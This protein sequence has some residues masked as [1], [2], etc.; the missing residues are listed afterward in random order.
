MNLELMP[1]FQLLEYPFNFETKSP[2]KYELVWV[3]RVI[4]I[5]AA[6][7]IFNFINNI[8][9]LNIKNISI[10]EIV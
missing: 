9:T 7:M 1:D 4:V 5:A 2:R 8:M 3:R 10:T 6:N